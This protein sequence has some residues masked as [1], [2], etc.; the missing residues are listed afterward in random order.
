MII[1]SS[2][3]SYSTAST[4][5][6]AYIIGGWFTHDLIAE[7]KNGEW[8]LFGKLMNGRGFH[9]S[10]ALGNEFMVIGGY[11]SDGRSV[12]SSKYFS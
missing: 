7:F 4:S 11:S 5:E 8:Q 1:L 2:I 9:G 12:N 10:I 6:A 3:E